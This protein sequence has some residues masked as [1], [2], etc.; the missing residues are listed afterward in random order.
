MSEPTAHQLRVA[1]AMRAVA[2]TGVSGVGASEYIERCSRYDEQTGCFLTFA[3]CHGNW[4][5]PGEN[6][7]FGFWVQLTLTRRD[8]AYR[9]LPWNREL[10][11]RW[12]L[13]F[14][15]EHRQMVRTDRA[16]SGFG[17]MMNAHHYRLFLDE[18]FANPFIPTGE[19]YGGGLQIH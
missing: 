5:G 9:P 19:H 12:V 13:A 15:G 1:A 6:P 4:E 8:K 11:E 17:M 7:R 3:R 16:T 18:K 10:A 2:K 14:F